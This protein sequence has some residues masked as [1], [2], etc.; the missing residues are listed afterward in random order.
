MRGRREPRKEHD[1]RGQNQGQPLGHL[2]LQDEGSGPD[3]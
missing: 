2:Q 3:D 1:P